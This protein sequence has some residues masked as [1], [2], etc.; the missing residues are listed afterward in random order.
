MYIFNCFLL[1]SLSFY[2]WSYKI[3][4]YN[5]KFGHSHVNFVSQISD[6]LVEAGHDVTVIVTEMDLNV[7]HPG[8]KKG[9]IYTA[10]SHPT[11]IQLMTDNI[12]LT[13]MWNRT[14]DFNRQVEMMNQFMTASNIQAKHTFYDKELGT[15][16][17]N[18]KFDI[19]FSELLHAHMF[20]LFKSWGIK[21]HVAGCATSLFDA[22][23][24]P[25][26]LPFPSSYVPN[27][28][29]PYTDKMNYKERFNNV[30][31]NFI[32]KLFI[33]LKGRKMV[34]Q[35]LFDEKYGEGKYDIRELVGDSS[36]V[37]IN[38]N[39]LFNLPG[40]KTPKMIE[41]GGIGISESKPLDDFWINILKV[42]QH[43]VLLS[44]GSIAKSSL[45]PKNFKK[46][47]IKTI[48]N[49]PNITF[50]WKYETPEDK[51]GDG[52][53]NLVLS[54]WIPQ[55][56][57]LNSSKMSLFITHGGLN[58]LTELAYQG[59]P[60]LAIPMFSDQFANSKLLERAGIG[61]YMPRDDL[62]DSNKFTLKIVSII[63]NSEYRR[64]SKILSKMLR[65]HPFNAKKELRKY[66]EFAAEFGKLPMLD[67]GRSSVPV[68]SFA[69][70]NIECIKLRASATIT[71]A[72]FQEGNAKKHYASIP[73][74]PKSAV[75]ENNSSCQILRKVDSFNIISQVLSL[76]FPSIYPGWG[77]TFY[78]TNDSTLFNISENNFGL[79]QIQI[80]ANFSSMPK[81]FNN[82]VL[83]THVYMSHLKFDDNNDLINSIY[84][85]TDH[86]YF[87]PSSQI[88]KL[89][90]SQ[91]DILEAS[92]T[93]KNFRVQ[94]F[95][96]ISI[97]NNDGHLKISNNYEIKNILSSSVSKF[98]TRETCPSD[99]TEADL[100]PVIA[101]SILVGLI[102]INLIFY[103]VYRCRLT[104]EVL[105]IVNSN[106][107]FTDKVYDKK[108]SDFNSFDHASTSNLD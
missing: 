18:Q 77:I 38:T 75:N 31:A 90:G 89:I 106:S 99:Q 83:K 52:I 8:T 29:N 40:A 27:L 23:Y 59:V 49:L 45:M 10:S 70:N 84:A 35:D 51:I 17:K 94:A 82:S 97:I 28:M 105:M 67:L 87:C 20:G 12:L 43:N 85:Q 25:F 101:G 88:Y 9:K 6:I 81:V 73:L 48:K 19:A 76:N 63:N 16:V 74:L 5:P 96:N 7:K 30:I 102:L 22:M 46:S 53:D 68:W 2:S 57:L 54:K 14:N 4:L 21:V 92:I 1:L 3:V 26:G 64:K 32:N 13:D 79:Y 44:F 42:R 65:N 66:F 107:H 93:L 71:L 11:T 36:F 50:I 15:F 91:E 69:E 95:T 34:L 58:S 37:F 100:V 103:L 47:I 72:Y 41:I 104:N 62:A 56:D 80:N 39:P 108:M 78:F 24:A 55:N 98:L 60:A 86:S 61:E 33:I